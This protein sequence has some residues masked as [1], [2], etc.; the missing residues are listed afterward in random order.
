MMV[1]KCS[2]LVW[3]DLVAASVRVAVGGSEPSLFACMP[4]LVLGVV[5]ADVRLCVCSSRGLARC[6]VSALDV[7]KAG[8]SIAGRKLGISDGGGQSHVV[9]AE[10]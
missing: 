3:E 8:Q 1:E 10:M 5:T 7:D 6:R 9:R 2:V 4:L